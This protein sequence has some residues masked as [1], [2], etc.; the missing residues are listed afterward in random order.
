[1][2][3]RHW[4]IILILSACWL[5]VIDVAYRGKDTDRSACMKVIRFGGVLLLLP[6]DL[7]FSIHL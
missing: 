6:G 1:M 3:A 4:S 5:G 7:L 2:L